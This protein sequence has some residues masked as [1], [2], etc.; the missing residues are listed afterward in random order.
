MP[1][2][3]EHQQRAERFMHL[4]GH[5]VYLAPNAGTDAARLTHGDLLLEEALETIAAL[6]YMVATEDGE[7][8]CIDTLHLVPHNHGPNLVEIADGC[9]D[10]R[11]VATCTL[12]TCGI[13]DAP[14]QRL[15]DENNLSKFG[16]GG[17]RDPVT[18]KW[19]K[20]PDHC[21]PDIAG[22]L[23]RQRNTTYPPRARGD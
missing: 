6:G 3:S 8:H 1:V 15:V 4:A 23:V 16:P 9:A 22:E 10:L 18:G 5:T 17:R 2:K 7:I 20:P 14:L 13:A 21:P 11:F 12:S 19:L